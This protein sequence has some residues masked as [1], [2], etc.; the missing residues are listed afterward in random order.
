[1]NSSFVFSFSTEMAVE[2][3]KQ[4]RKQRHKV[5]ANNERIDKEAELRNHS[6]S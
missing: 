2:T 1:M 4:K 3:I 6:C 5:N